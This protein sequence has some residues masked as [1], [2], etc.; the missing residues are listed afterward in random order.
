MD[1]VV[2]MR[3][4]AYNK[5]KYQIL[6]GVYFPGQ[7]IS[8]K[9]VSSDLGIGRTPVREA[10]IRLERYSLVE[11][12]PQSGT[13]VTKIDMES[14]ENTQ[15]LRRKIDPDILLEFTIEASP[16]QFAKLEENLTEQ[17][18]AALDKDNDRFFDLDE[19]FHQLFYI[20]AK[21]EMIWDWLQT[22]NMHLNRYRW[23]R[24]N[25]EDLN[26]KT[27][28]QQHQGIY[29]AVKQKNVEAIRFNIEA[30]LRLMHSEAPALLERFP[31]YFKQ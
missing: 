24:L 17:K 30:H 22:I 9:I 1:N 27:L 13:Y 29:D 2:N 12:V 18:Q 19:Q 4:D 16:D 7:K 28:L 25:V 6:H 20:G 21:R 5:L 11:V 31:D 14:A 15:F 8:E 3:L 23:L 10:I 26:W